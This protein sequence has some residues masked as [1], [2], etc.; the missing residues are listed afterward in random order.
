MK[1]K[2]FNEAIQYYNKSIELD[3]NQAA[4][5]CNRALAYLKKKGIILIK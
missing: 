4:T 5:Y 3:P 2:D 1:S